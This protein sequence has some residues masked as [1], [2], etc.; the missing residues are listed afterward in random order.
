MPD[1]PRMPPSIPFVAGQGMSPQ[2]QQSLQSSPF[3]DGTARRPGILG[4]PPSS[5][6]NIYGGHG[7]ANIVPD[8]TSNYP[9]RGL[10][11]SPQDSALLRS[12][13]PMSPEFAN[14][15]YDA[16]QRAG[17]GT[18]VSGGQFVKNSQFGIMPGAENIAKLLNGGGFGGQ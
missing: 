5:G 15:I 2:M 8:T 13:Q 7:P 4:S 16:Y 11:A 9:S 17:G 6:A 14:Q 1:T 10:P 12:D 18:D 3:D